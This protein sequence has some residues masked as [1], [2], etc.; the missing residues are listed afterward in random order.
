MIREQKFLASIY[1]EDEVDKTNPDDLTIEDGYKG[2]LLVGDE[3]I[4]NDW[5]LKALDYMKDQNKIHKKVVWIILKRIIDLFKS[6][7][8]LKEVSI[9]E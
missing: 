6:E 4:T 7:P 3:P 9:P 2:P 1:R 8:T 5:C